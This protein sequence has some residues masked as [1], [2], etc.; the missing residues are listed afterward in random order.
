MPNCP[1]LRHSAKRHQCLEVPSVDVSDAGCYNVPMPT[2]P[3]RR[4]YEYGPTIFLVA[5]LI[6]LLTFWLFFQLYPDAEWHGVP[7][8]YYPQTDYH[9]P[10][11]GLP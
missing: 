11:G 7:S 6:S 2:P 5:S 4:W 9:M 8:P 3:C 1:V 10:K